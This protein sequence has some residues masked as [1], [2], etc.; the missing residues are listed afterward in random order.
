MA[1]KALKITFAILSQ[2]FAWFIFGF[3]IG[4][5]TSSGQEAQFKHA[6]GVGFLFV[7]ISVVGIDLYLRW[8]SYWLKK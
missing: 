1:T 5:W 2:A 4:Y 6:I 8:I 3:V 7:A